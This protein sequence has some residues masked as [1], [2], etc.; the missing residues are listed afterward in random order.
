MWLTVE[1]IENRE[2]KD[3]DAGDGSFLRQSLCPHHLLADICRLIFSFLSLGSPSRVDDSHQE[4]AELQRI[5]TGK[6]RSPWAE[7]RHQVTQEESAAAFL[8]PTGSSP[9]EESDIGALETSKH[10]KNCLWFTYSKETDGL[11]TC[12]D[13]SISFLDF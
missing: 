8:S 13:H 5:S 11:S 4:V 7:L 10:L 6:A 9:P 12:E 3:T 2:E 1:Q